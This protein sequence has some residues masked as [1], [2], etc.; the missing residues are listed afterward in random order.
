MM[1]W[2][3]PFCADWV[4]GFTAD[5]TDGPRTFTAAIR[6]WG[7]DEEASKVTAEVHFRVLLDMHEIPW[8]KPKP[9]G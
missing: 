7:A 9:E 8:R 5:T 1:R 6:A 2:E 4:P 3:D